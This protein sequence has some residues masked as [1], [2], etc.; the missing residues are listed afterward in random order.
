[1]R[2]FSHLILLAAGLLALAGPAV[3]AQDVA[4]APRATIQQ[5]SRY[6]SV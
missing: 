4:P 5:I 2:P 6:A 3:R 1:M